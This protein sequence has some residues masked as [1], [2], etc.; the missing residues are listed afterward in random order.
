MYIWKVLDIHI[1]PNGN[2]HRIG[3]APHETFPKVKYDAHEEMGGDRKCFDSPIR[4]W[5]LVKNFDV[6][7]RRA[8][9]LCS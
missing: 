5:G 1:V 2:F 4:K 3:G 7:S 6:Y 8:L 9:T